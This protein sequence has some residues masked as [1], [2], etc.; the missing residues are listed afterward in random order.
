MQGEPDAPGRQADLLVYGV[1]RTVERRRLRQTPRLAAAGVLAPE[2]LLRGIP[3]KEDWTEP[4]FL[5][6]QSWTRDQAHNPFLINALHDAGNRVW[7]L[8]P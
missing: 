2:L 1:D 5:A 6:A 8:V 3:P 7:N 4:G